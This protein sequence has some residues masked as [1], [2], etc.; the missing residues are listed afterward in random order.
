MYRNEYGGDVSFLAIEDVARL[1]RERHVSPV[2]LVEAALDRIDAHDKD[3]RAFLHVDAEGTLAA[4]GECERAIM[5][6]AAVG[7]LCGIPIAVKDIVDVAGLPTTAASRVLAGNVARAD[8]AIVGRLRAAGA[9]IIGKTNTHEFAYG[10]ISAPTRN[11]WDLARIPGGSSGG[12]A[13]AL[14]AGMAMGAIG[15]DTAGSIRLPS[16]LCGVVGLK[17]TYDLVDRHGVIPLSWSLDHAGPM[18]RGVADAALLL[19]VMAPQVRV[20]VGHVED[21]QEHAAAVLAQLDRPVTGLRMG[22]PRPYFYD[23]L[24]PEVEAAVAQALRALGRLGLE[25]REVELPDVALTFAVGRAVQRPEASAYHQKTLRATPELYEDETR[26]DLELG[27]LYLATDYLQGQRVRAQLRARWLSALREV[28]VLITPTV[29]VTA[30][31][32]PAEGSGGS[33]VV[34]GTLLRNTY[35]FNLAG[36]PALSVPCGFTSAGLPIGLQIV[37][38]PHEDLTALRVGRHYQQASA[39]QTRQPPLTVL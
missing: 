8:A 21:M 18:A 6:G 10:V 20:G 32:A 29:P 15:T 24:D 16:A 2:E 5:A 3:V 38:R 1:V 11:P 35:P 36:F 33:G 39:W 19:A 22:V 31:P 25:Q 9:V 13:A 37:G 26:R 23:D 34:K 12:S 4:A 27:A 28:D 14:A 17:P 7:P 30:P